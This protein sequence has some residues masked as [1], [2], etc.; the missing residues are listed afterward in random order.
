MSKVTDALEEARSSAQMLHKKIQVTTAK[1]H[2][3]VRAN[4]RSVAAEALQ[5][6]RAVKGLLESQRTDTR[7][8]LKDAAT[9]LEAAAKDAQA[10]ETASDAEVRSRNRETLGRV[11]SAAQELSQA[12]AAKRASLVKA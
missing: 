3:A 12:V 4:A 7:Q 5:L 10:I 9:A 1:D 8:H 11:R 2:A 6:A